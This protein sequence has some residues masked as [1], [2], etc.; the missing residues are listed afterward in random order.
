MM[1][2][3]NSNFD[4]RRQDENNGNGPSVNIGDIFSKPAPS[5]K[6]YKVLKVL[7]I[8]GIIMNFSSAIQSLIGLPYESLTDEVYAAVPAL[9]TFS[10]FEGLFTLG[11]GVLGIFTVVSLSGFKEKGPKLL[12]ILFILTSVFPLIYMLVFDS[13]TANLKETIVTDGEYYIDLANAV[14]PISV[15][16]EVGVKIAYTVFNYKYFKAREDIFIK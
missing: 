14:N 15:F 1:Q 2:N 11:I 9:R 4:E 8:F 6:W 3:D 7:L 13:I 10:I 16:V 12:L 5:M